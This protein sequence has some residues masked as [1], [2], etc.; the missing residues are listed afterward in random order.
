MCVIKNLENYYVFYILCFI[1]SSSVDFGL[2][3]AAN[4]CKS[5]NA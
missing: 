5:H 1:C 2:R 3:I 4:N